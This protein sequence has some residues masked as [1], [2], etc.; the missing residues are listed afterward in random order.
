MFRLLQLSVW[1]SLNI[2]GI[3]TSLWS[4]G[5]WDPTSN[6]LRKI[7]NKCRLEVYTYTLQ[8]PDRQTKTTSAKCTPQWDTLTII[9]KIYIHIFYLT[10]LIIHIFLM[11][12]NLMGITIDLS[13]WE[14]LRSESRFG[15]SFW[16]ILGTGRE[17]A[18]KVI[19]LWSHHLGPNTPPLSLDVT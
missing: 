7:I 6:K 13:F 16:K 18:K 15:L 17:A 5:V 9:Y 3:F 2:W 4:I 8:I 12:F 14:W 11:W 19:F 1:K 10:I